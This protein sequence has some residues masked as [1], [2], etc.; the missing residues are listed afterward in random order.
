[1]KAKDKPQPEKAK[2]KKKAWKGKK[3]WTIE[4]RVPGMKFMKNNMEWRVYNR[5]HSEKKRNQAFNDLSKGAGILAEL[6]E[7]RKG[8]DGNKKKNS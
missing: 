7:Y 4:Y 5:Y 8:K 6:A 3:P 2:H 1:M